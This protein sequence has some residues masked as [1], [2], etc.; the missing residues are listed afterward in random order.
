M[1]DDARILMDRDRRRA[2]P[3]LSDLEGAGI[4]D[5]RAARQD[6]LA[7]AILQKLSAREQRKLSSALHLLAQITED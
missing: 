5:G 3:P 7:Q 4:E 2:E 6:W 1:A